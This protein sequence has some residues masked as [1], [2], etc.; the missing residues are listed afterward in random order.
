MARG[1]RELRAHPFVRISGAGLRDSMPNAGVADLPF[2]AAPGVLIL[3]SGGTLQTKT[4]AIEAGVPGDRSI[5]FRLMVHELVASRAATTRQ[6]IRSSPGRSCF[7]VTRVRA[8]GRRG[9]PF[10]RRGPRR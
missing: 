5:A 6:G 10:R 1:A 4:P 8:P 2:G 3:R 7:G 9:A